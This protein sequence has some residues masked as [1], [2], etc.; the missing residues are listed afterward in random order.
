VTHY[1]VQN[2]HFSIK[3]SNFLGIKLIALDEQF[4]LEEIQLACKGE[5][6]RENDNR[7]KLN[8]SQTMNWV[9]KDA[10][11]SERFGLHIF[12]RRSLTI[13][14]SIICIVG[15]EGHNIWISLICIVG[16]EGHNI[17]FLQITMFWREPRTTSG[18]RS[19]HNVWTRSAPRGFSSPLGITSLTSGDQRRRR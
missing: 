19:R 13:W 2:Y 5:H 6:A 4:I 11:V 8:Y 3:T 16:Y 12:Y 14:M 15:Y 17:V 18:R 9:R 7:W 1:F 10:R